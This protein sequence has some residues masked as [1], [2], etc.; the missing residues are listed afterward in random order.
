MEGY[1][2]E[3]AASTIKIEDIT[4]DDI[5]LDILPAGSSIM[6]G[7]L[8]SFMVMGRRQDNRDY[9]PEGALTRDG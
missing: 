4:A 7:I 2:C 9:R 6:M 8:R 1:D 3:A 5:N